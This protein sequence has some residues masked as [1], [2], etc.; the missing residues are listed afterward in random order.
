M[1]V[2]PEVSWWPL[3]KKI[4]S[5]YFSFWGTGAEHVGL[6]HRY[7][8]GKVV[9]SLH[10]PDTYILH[11]S[12]CYPSLTSP[13]SYCTFL[14]PPQRTPVC[15][16]PLSVSMCSHCSIP[17]YEWE[18]AV[19]DFSV[20]ASVCRELWFPDSSMSLKRTRTHHFLWLHSIPWC[21][22]ATCSLS[23]LSSMGIWVGSRSLLL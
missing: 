7:T 8:H 18:H 13:H 11:F 22:C 20:L 1:T 3:F 6:L 19:C 21:I 5:L 16:A 10:P 12:P 14:G 9:C 17:T 2:G 4:F 23:S 15:D